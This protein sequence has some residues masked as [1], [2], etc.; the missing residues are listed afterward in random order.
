MSMVTELDTDFWRKT[1]HLRI[2]Q[3]LACSTADQKVVS[4]N[5][6]LANVNLS[7]HKR[8]MCELV[9]REGDACASLIFLGAICWLHP[10]HRE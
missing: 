5:P 2:V 8:P 10:K 6:T 1:E 9:F 3:W 7:W 4:S